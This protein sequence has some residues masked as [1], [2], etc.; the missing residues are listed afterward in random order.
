MHDCRGY[1]LPIFLEV[2]SLPLLGFGFPFLS[3]WQGLQQWCQLFHSFCAVLFLVRIPWYFSG[4]SELCNYREVSVFSLVTLSDWCP[5]QRVLCKWLR[6]GRNGLQFQSVHQLSAVWISVGC[7]SPWCPWGLPDSHIHPHVPAD[8]STVLIRW[9]QVILLASPFQLA[10]SPDIFVLTA[11][12]SALVLLTISISVT[13]TLSLV[14]WKP[15]C[16]ET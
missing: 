10:F 2:S 16:W 13:R 1:N 14:A 9:S 5:V 15:K 4:I 8:L 3:W 6:A 11:F 12:L 7:L